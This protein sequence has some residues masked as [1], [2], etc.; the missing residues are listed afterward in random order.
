M[1][2]VQ[3]LQQQQLTATLLITYTT[4]LRLETNALIT[5]S[6]MAREHVHHQV[7]AKELQDLPLQQQQLPQPLQ[8]KSQ[9]PVPLLQ[10]QCQMTQHQ[11][12]MLLLK[13]HSNTQ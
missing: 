6:V 13:V 7:Y 4:K 1:L 9:L 10:C 8:V 12:G 2:Q 11:F 3:Q 5:A